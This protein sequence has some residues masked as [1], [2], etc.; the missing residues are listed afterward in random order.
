MNVGQEQIYPVAELL[1]ARDIP[2]AFVTGYGIESVDARFRH[3]PTL[4]KPID[5][6]ALERIFVVRPAG[7]RLMRIP[8]RNT[9]RAVPLP[10]DRDPGSAKRAVANFLVQDASDPSKCARLAAERRMIDDAPEGALCRSVRE[11]V[12]LGALERWRNKRKF[13]FGFA[14][15]A[16]LRRVR[17][18]LWARYL[19]AGGTAVSDLLPR[20]HTNQLLCRRVARA[21]GHRFVQLGGMVLLSSPGG[22][23]EHR[24]LPGVRRYVF[25]PH[26]RADDCLDAQFERRH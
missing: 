6:R 12:V 10:S 4:Q 16:F 11:H 18:A 17:R 25:H 19:A 13:S 9:A 8:V 5:R 24:F 22:I 26:R 7:E 15:I 23:L 21:S 3:I 2:F 1:Q 20:R 14:V